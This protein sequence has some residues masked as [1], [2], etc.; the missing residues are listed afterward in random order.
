M[1]TITLIE[2]TTSAVSGVEVN[3]SSYNEGLISADNLATTETVTV[4][5]RGQTVGVGLT[6]SDQSEQLPGRQIY[7]V[8]KSATAAACGVYLSI[9]NV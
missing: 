6:A 1:A 9:G 3:L 4:R 8:E 2:P 5:F 7:T